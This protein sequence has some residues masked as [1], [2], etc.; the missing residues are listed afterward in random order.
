LEGRLSSGYRFFEDVY[1]QGRRTRLGGDIE[2]SPGSLQFTAEA[3][4]V[5]DERREQG[6]DVDDLPALVGTAAY[7]TTRWRFAPRRDVLLRYEY[8]G[9]DD[10]GP[11]T[12]MAS[13]R[14]RAADVRARAAQAVTLGGSWGVTRWLRLMGNA[15][16]EWFSDPRTAPKAGDDRGYWTLATRA[17]LELPAILRLRI[18]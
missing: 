7:F 5:R 6:V 10:A 3:L 8:A 16:V 17:Q 13:V 2:W 18:R 14:P 12:A 9:F 1:V 11:D 4:R 15:G